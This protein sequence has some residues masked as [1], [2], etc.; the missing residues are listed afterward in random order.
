MK[1]TRPRKG[2]QLSK[3]AFFIIGPESSGT[4]MMAQAFVACGAYGDGGH[5]Q[6][7]DS[8]GFGG[9]HE[10]IVLRRSVPHG[11]VMPQISKL[12]QRMRKNNYQVVPIVI[13]R[14]KDKCAA[15]QVKNRHAA[16]VS[17][18]KQSIK[19]AIDHI[20]QQLA[21]FQNHVHVIHYEPFVK[22]KK[23]RSGFFRRLGFDHPD[24]EFYNANVKYK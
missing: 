5:K 13:L 24:M 16:N 12:I 21:G 17:D 22:N 2:E 8:E 14:D 10:L 11:M 20:Y 18:A 7:L 1:S 6:R 23:I 4:R 3:R 9:K 15:S 19:E